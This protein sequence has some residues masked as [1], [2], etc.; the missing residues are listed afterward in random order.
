MIRFTRLCSLLCVLVLAACESAEPTIVWDQNGSPTKEQIDL[1]DKPWKEWGEKSKVRRVLANLFPTATR[2]RV[3][4]GD[5]GIQISDGGKA[6][7]QKYDS[8]ADKMPDV[9]AKGGEYLTAAE[10]KVLRDSVFYTLSPPAI[11]SCCIPRHG[12]LFYDK[13]GKYLGYLKVCYE[14]GCAEI[15][16]HSPHDK[17]LDW[18]EWDAA[19]LRKIIE[20][21]HLAIKPQQPQKAAKHLK[22]KA[23]H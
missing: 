23:K 15:S 5:F 7:T 16:S 9:P 20:A 10:I 2:V 17:A 1:W 18:I 22:T 14:C 12:F 11:A 13:A 6:S 19:A 4:Q 8:D 3:Y 21:H